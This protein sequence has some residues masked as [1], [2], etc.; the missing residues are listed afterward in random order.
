MELHK[1]LQYLK[2]VYN[3]S[4]QSVK[5]VSNINVL[6]DKNKTL[7]RKNA[8]PVRTADYL[9]EYFVKHDDSGLER[10][11][12]KDLVEF[13]IL[14]KWSHEYTKTEIEDKELENKEI[15]DQVASAI[16]NDLSINKARFYMVTV[17]VYLEDGSTGGKVTTTISENGDIVID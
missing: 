11:T 7:T 13:D 15:T 1:P 6:V 4:R 2:F 9:I 3:K 17:V 14:P 5:L 10:N 16:K 8:V 12:F